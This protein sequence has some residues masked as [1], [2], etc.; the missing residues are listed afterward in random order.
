MSVRDRVFKVFKATF[1]FGDEVDTRTLE[2]RKYAAWTSMGHM[3]LAAALEEEFGVM[4]E[5]EEVLA[6]SNFDKAVEIMTKH[7]SH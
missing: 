2:Y 1:D 5:T 6:M 7:C 3:V 4:L